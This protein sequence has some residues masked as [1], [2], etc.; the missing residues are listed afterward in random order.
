MVRS[1]SMAKNLTRLCSSAPQKIRTNEL[2]C[3]FGLGS[4]R[5]ETQFL[6]VYFEIIVFDPNN[7]CVLFSIKYIKKSSY[8]I[9]NINY[10]KFILRERFFRDFS[11]LIPS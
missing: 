3:V 4:F 7:V 8:S 2:D 6:D 11:T 5:T 1:S 9:F 10:T